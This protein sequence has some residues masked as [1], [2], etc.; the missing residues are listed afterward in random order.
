M[1]VCVDRE[2]LLKQAE[3]TYGEKPAGFGVTD[4]DLFEILISPS[5]SWTVIQTLPNKPR[6]SCPIT[7]GHGASVPDRGEML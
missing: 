3:A 2:K 7:A 5:G 6:Q 1:Q 4:G